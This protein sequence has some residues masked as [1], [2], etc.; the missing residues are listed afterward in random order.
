FMTGLGGDCFM[1]I[2]HNG[3]KRLYGLN[4]S[5]R[6]PRAATRDAIVERGHSQMP[7]LGMLAVTGPGAG[8]AW[9]TALERFGS[10]SLA[11]VVAPAIHYAEDG[12]A[13]SEIIATQW[14]MVA[15]LLQQEEA[16]RTFLIDGRPPRLGEH[17]RLPGLARSLRALAA[18]GR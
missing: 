18:G 16:Q 12:F 1:L 14:A 6:A 7:M 17:V 2:W 10:R 4:G 9:C 11:R 5:G 8:D 3:E 13:V 15:G